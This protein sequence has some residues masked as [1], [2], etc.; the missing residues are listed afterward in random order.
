MAFDFSKQYIDGQWVPSASDSWIGV[1]NPATCE[2]FAKVPDG[3]PADVDRAVEAAHRAQP[4]WAAQPLAERI[5]LMRR[6]L[7]IFRSM[8]DEITELETKELGSPTAFSRSSQVNYQYDRV[9]SYIR[10]AETLPLEEDFPC[11]AVLREPV[12]VVAC[13]TPWNYPLGQL[14]QKVIPAVLMGNTVVMKPSQHTPLTAYYM[15]EAFDRAGFPKGV[16]NLVSG[17]GRTLGD[18][19]ATHPLID[20]ISF[21]GSTKVGIELAQKALAGMKRVSLELG[22][23]SPF[24]WL[25]G[26]KDYA[27]AVTKLYDS[28]LLNSGQTCTA[29]SRL[30]VPESMLSDVKALLLKTLADYPVGDPTDPASKIGP[31]ASAAQYRKIREYI[32]LGLE[33]GA[34]LLA[35]EVPPEKPE[36]G[37]Y[38]KP[39][40]FVNVNNSMRI[41]QEEIFGPVLCVLTYRDLDEAVAIANDTPYGLNAAVYGPK[42][43]AVA[44]AKRIKSG[45]VYVNDGPR[46]ITAPFGG[47]KASGIGREGGPLGLLEFTQPKAIFEHGSML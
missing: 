16:V 38:I 29:L 40:I 5:A 26:M 22:G 47:Y 46:D 2:V 33:E 15:T 36:G 34:E 43:E 27:P 11:S 37:Y 28:I 9:E 39:A 42:A 17:R 41:A 35:G 13:V 23:K 14:V 3:C 10:C 18:R 44:V 20:M 4:A 6:M 30:L 31:V 45:N 12:G 21:T 25:P 32:Q 1:E 8:G 24:I 19:L 7:G